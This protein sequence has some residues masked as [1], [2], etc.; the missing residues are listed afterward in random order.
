[1][2][3]AHVRTLCTVTGPLHYTLQT[4]LSAAASSS[5]PR[6]STAETSRRESFEHYSDNDLERKDRNIPV[7]HNVDSTTLSFCWALISRNVSVFVRCVGFARCVAVSAF[8]YPRDIRPRRSFERRYADADASATP[9]LGLEAA[10]RRWTKSTWGPAETHTNRCQSFVDDAG[11]SGLNLLNFIWETRRER[12]NGKREVE[13]SMYAWAGHRARADP[14]TL[15]ASPAHKPRS[16]PRSTPCSTSPALTYVALRQMGV[17]G[18]GVL[19]GLRIE[20]RYGNQQDYIVWI[21]CAPQM[22][23]R[24][25]CPSRGAPPVEDV[26][27]GAEPMLLPPRA[28]FALAGAVTEAEPDEPL[29]HVE[30]EASKRKRRD[31]GDTARAHAQRCG[32]RARGVELGA[33]GPYTHHAPAPHIAA[34]PYSHCHRTLE[35]AITLDVKDVLHQSTPELNRGFICPLRDDGHLGGDSVRKRERRYGE[36]AEE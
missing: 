35:H 20:M 24:A 9:L 18:A 30:E 7:V 2:W 27:H 36:R 1:M 16:T 29:P 10:Q 21:W 28:V 11:E 13:T 19:A 34:T 23:R 33:D 12:K 31:D 8:L 17:V 25:R 32:G 15:C 5:I 6:T 14:T 26:E 22:T 4:A 3:G